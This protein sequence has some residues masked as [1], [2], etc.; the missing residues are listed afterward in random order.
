MCFDGGVKAKVRHATTEM[1]IVFSVTLF[2]VTLVGQM[3]KM[4]PPQRKVLRHISGMIHCTSQRDCVKEHPTLQVP[5]AL[6]I[7]GGGRILQLKTLRPYSSFCK[8]FTLFPLLS[9]IYVDVFLDILANQYKIQLHF[10]YF[11]I[12]CLYAY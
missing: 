6:R 10:S 7:Y 3:V 4:L 5:K 12:C 8:I 2:S 1:V 9:Y 11:S